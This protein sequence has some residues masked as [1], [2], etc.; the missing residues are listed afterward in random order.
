MMKNT[1]G[2][3][4]PPDRSLPSLKMTARSY[5]WTTLIV[6]RREKGSVATIRMKDTMVSRKLHTPGPSSHAEM[7][8]CYLKECLGEV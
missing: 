2:P 8:P 5:S 4:A 1:P 7:C 6:Y 3:L